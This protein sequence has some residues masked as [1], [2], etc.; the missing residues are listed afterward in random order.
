[1]YIHLGEPTYTPAPPKGIV[2]PP[3]PPPSAPAPA[4]GVA[5]P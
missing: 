4:Q 2:I 1:M 3:P 5:T